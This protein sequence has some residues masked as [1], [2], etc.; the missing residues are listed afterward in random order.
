[1]EGVYI[2]RGSLSYSS[3]FLVMY[4]PFIN[5]FSDV[6][7]GLISHIRY[8]Y[9]NSKHKN[10]LCRVVPVTH[11]K[12]NTVASY[13]EEKYHDL[14]LDAAE[15]ALRYFGFDASVY[16]RSENGRNTIKKKKWQVQ[17]RNLL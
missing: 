11:E 10:P 8:I 16:K 1:M 12:E 15:T 17:I 2:F 7:F 14:L 13:D 9:T 5:I 6:S 3:T 4:L